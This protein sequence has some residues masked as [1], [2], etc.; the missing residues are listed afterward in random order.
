M[1][2]AEAAIVGSGRQAAQV[3]LLVALE[4]A[5]GGQANGLG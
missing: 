5:V 1:A 2:E 4:L 3:R